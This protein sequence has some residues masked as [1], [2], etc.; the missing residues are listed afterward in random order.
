MRILNARSFARSI[1]SAL[2]LTALASCGDTRVVTRTETVTVK[3]PVYVALPDN[4]LQV[5]QPKYR[6]PADALP[7]AALEDK[8]EALELALGMCNNDK[9]L[10]RATQPKV[11]DQA[12]Q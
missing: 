7:V 6:Y 8:I 9:E 12:D 10:I 4:L 2:V 3:V 11:P 5:C 1:F